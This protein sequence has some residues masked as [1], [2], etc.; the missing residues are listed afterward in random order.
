MSHDR[1]EAK[2]TVQVIDNS[3]SYVWSVFKKSNYKFKKFGI[4]L[5]RKN[6]QH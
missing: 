5:I 4:I 1:D 2:K 3:Y 6:L